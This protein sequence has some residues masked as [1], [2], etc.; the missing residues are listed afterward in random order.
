MLH[1]QIDAKGNKTE[2]QYDEHKRLKKRV[3]PSPGSVGSVNASD[4]NEYGYDSN[5]NVT[6]ERKRNGQTI[7]NTFDDNN[8]LTFKNLSD[9][10]YSA[11]IT[12]NYDLRGLTL[13]SCFGSTDACVSSGEGETN[14]FDGFGNLSSRTSRMAG[15]AADAGLINTTARATARR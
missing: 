14:V 11:D 7:A 5:G 10:T 9:N 2:L 1:F 8:R 15:T 12:Y 4:Y 6:Y 3:Y 13:S